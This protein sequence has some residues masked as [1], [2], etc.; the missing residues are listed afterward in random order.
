MSD[1]LYGLQPDNPE[2][3]RQPRLDGDAR[4]ARHADRQH[5]LADAHVGQP[6]LPPTSP[7]AS[8]RHRP[9]GQATSQNQG[10]NHDRPHHRPPPRAPAVRPHCS[11]PSARPRWPRPPRSSRALGQRARRALISPCQRDRP[12]HRHACRTRRLRRELALVRRPV[13]QQ[14]RLGHSRYLSVPFRRGARRRSSTAA[15][16]GLPSSSSSSARTGT[17]TTSCQFLVRR[18]ASGSAAGTDAP[19]RPRWRPPAGRAQ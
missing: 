14:P 7:I 8:R 5:R 6:V 16:L 9:P 11:P 15:N 12:A 3:R 2:V 19:R 10:P 18:E 13:R 1:S 17:S 4:R